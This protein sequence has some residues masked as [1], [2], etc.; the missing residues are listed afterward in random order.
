MKTDEFPEEIWEAYYAGRWVA[1]DPPVCSDG[2]SDA[3]WIRWI[4]V[5]NFDV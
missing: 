4:G 2:W 1:G 5:E 3:D